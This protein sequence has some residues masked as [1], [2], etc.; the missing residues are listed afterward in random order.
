MVNGPSLPAATPGSTV[1]TQTP[2]PAEIL[3]RLNGTRTTCGTFLVVY[4]PP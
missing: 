2:L 1:Y 4:S 3:A